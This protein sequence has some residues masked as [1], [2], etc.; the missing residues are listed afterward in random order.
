[1]GTQENITE[2][3]CALL[4]K[5]FDIAEEKLEERFWKEPL[6]GFHF[7]LSGADLVYLLF[8]AEKTFDI[9]ITE[10]QLENY[11]FSTIEK[12]AGC[13]AESIKG[14]RPDRKEAAFR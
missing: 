5:H 9:K 6:T 12:V 14:R 7:G 4:R 1:M 13:V 3:I 8:E 10:G 2:I 11:G